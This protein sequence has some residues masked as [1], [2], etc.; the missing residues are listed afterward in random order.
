MGNQLETIKQAII[1]GKHMEIEALVNQALEEKTD[2]NELINSAMIGAMDVVG[3]KFSSGEYFVPEML[4]AAHTMKKGLDLVRPLLQGRG[5]DTR[6]TI[7]MCTVKGD[8]HDIGKNLVAMMLEGAGFDV[9]NLGVDI[10]VDDLLGKI[11]EIKPSVVGL[12]ALLTT[13]MPEMENVI[14]AL[15]EK[16]LRQGTKV[17]I[18]GA[19]VS[20]AFATKIGADGFGKDAAEAV[21]VAKQLAGR[22]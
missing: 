12:S 1:E 2:L 6:D 22:N 9:V 7:V 11:Q 19:P 17:M 18:G 14:K 10:G 20:E 5:E 15:D 4:V 16:G 13:T 8:L 21:K 3:E